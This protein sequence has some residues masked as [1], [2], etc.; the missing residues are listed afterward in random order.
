M[1]IGKVSLVQ[2]LQSKLETVLNVISALSSLSTCIY[3]HIQVNCIP[4][5]KSKLN[6]NNPPNSPACSKL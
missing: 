4:N 6:V 5:E 1:T 2:L 3:L